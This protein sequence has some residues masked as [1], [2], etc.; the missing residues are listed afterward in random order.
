M[1]NDA[2]AQ[3]AVRPDPN[4]LIAQGGNLQT[5]GLAAI[6]SGTGT[7]DKQAT[8]T[9]D[10]TSGGITRC[11][12]RQPSQTTT[13]SRVGTATLDDNSIPSVKE[14]SPPDSES[15][16]SPSLPR[17]T[18]LTLIPRH[19]YPHLFAYHWYRD[20]VYLIVCQLLM[21][22]CVILWFQGAIVSI[23]GISYIL[24][25]RLFLIWI[26]G[27]V[28]MSSVAHLAAWYLAASVVNRIDGAEEWLSGTGRHGR[29]DG[30]EGRRWWGTMTMGRCVYYLL[31]LLLKGGLLAVTFLGS[32][33]IAGPQNI[34]LGNG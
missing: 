29:G 9:H 2:K 24:R 13:P 27:F 25:S 3:D 34:D 5:I 12:Y 1:D 20:H 6:G 28:P 14:F 26:F 11:N 8:S 4:T 16:H 21:V 22:G 32:T 33:I 17:T 30:A 15:Q 18:F 31:V 23:L 19:P 7:G 10:V